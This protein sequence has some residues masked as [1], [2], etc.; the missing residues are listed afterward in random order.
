MIRKYIKKW[1]NLYDIE[2]LVVGAHCGVCGHWIANEIVERAWPWS[3]CKLQD[4]EGNCLNE[5]HD[6]EIS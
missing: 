6:D 5:S 2:D 1:F 3:L 4:E